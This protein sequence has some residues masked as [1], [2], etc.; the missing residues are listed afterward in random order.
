VIPIG[1]ELLLANAGLESEYVKTVRGYLHQHPEVSGQEYDTASFLRSELEGIGLPVEAVSAT[2]LIA[3]LDTG[4]EGPTVALRA[5]IDALPMSESPV[6][7]KSTKRFVSERPGVSHTCGHDGHMAMLLGVARALTKMKNLL[8][9]RVLFCF[10]EGE[11][12]GSGIDGMMQAL[13]QYEVAAVWGIHLTSFME[14]GTISVDAGPR[15]AGDT[16]V[17]FDVIGKGG[18]GSRPDLSINPVFAAAHVLTALGSAWPNRIDANETVTL[19]IATINGGTAPNIIPDRVRISGT[20]R[21]FNVGEGAKAVEVLKHVALNAAKAHLCDVHFAE[22]AFRISPPVI[23]P[24]GLSK[25]AAACLG[26]IL[27][28][29]T[30]VHQEKWYAS[31]SFRSYGAKYPAVLAFVGA[32]NADQGMGAE[33]HNVHFDIDE[34]ALDLGVLATLKFAV[35]VLMSDEVKVRGW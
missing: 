21:F 23:N 2:G 31:E 19:G 1:N 20:L 18:H 25:F 6:N 7:L 34:T 29:G 8:R 15:M 16:Q 24:E 13:S 5:D 10:E 14:S 27:P 33:H 30:V 26:D 3:L 22:N 28:A 11:E 9:G 17:H 4:R 12:T 32:G 35:E